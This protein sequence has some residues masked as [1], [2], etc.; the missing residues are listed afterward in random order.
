[1][2]HSIY[3]LAIA[4]LCCGM[5]CSKSKDETAAGTTAGQNTTLPGT[6]SASS[7]APAV[8]TQPAT[9][10]TTPAVTAGL[11][12]AHGQPGHRCD[13][14]VGAPLNSPPG[15]TANSGAASTPA[16]RPAGLPP[17]PVLPVGPPVVTAQGMNPPHGQ[18]GH[19]CSIAVGAPLKK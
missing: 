9:T 14:Q 13:I 3:I 6:T 19:D 2:K 10:T 12:P 8:T 18:P 15:V 17:A 16:A 4:S 7:P 11:N 5:G 1:M